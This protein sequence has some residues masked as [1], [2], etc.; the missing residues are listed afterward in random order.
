MKFL[1]STDIDKTIIVLHNQRGAF[2]MQKDMGKS[3]EEGKSFLPETKLKEWKNICAETYSSMNLGIGEKLLWKI[4]KLFFHLSK[5]SH[6]YEKS[7]SYLERSKL[8]QQQEKYVL[9]MIARLHPWGE[10]FR[11]LIEKN[12]KI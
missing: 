10:I 9:G 4:L 12:I 8:S 2:K 11:K 6:P 3:F 1:F 5:D 7:R